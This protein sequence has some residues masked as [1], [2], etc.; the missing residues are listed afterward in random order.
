MKQLSLSRRQSPSRLSPPHLLL[1]SPSSRSLTYLWR[2][3]SRGQHPAS[4]RIVE[5]LSGNTFWGFSIKCGGQLMQSKR[6]MGSQDKK[7]AWRVSWITL[8]Q[9][10][11]CSV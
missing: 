10:M 2:K 4:C 1:N 8:F 3:V 5:I 11:Y 7:K 6:L 9:K